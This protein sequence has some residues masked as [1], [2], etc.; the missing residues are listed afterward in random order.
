MDVVAITLIYL[1]FTSPSHFPRNRTCV[2]YNKYVYYLFK[3]GL[4]LLWF[5]PMY[6]YCSYRKKKREK[7]AEPWRL[8]STVHVG[9]HCDS[10]RRRRRCCCCRHCCCCCRRR[11]CC[12]RHCCCC[13]RHYCCVVVAPAADA[14]LLPLLLLLP[15]SPLLLLLPSLLLLLLSLLLLLGASA[16]VIAAVADVTTATS[17][18]GHLALAVFRCF[19]SPRAS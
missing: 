5:L 15:L 19:S 10:F 13:C 14:S 6:M 4:A 3:E 12:C 16:A 2:D 9:G 11:C 8:C 7:R 17:G 1:Y 18:K